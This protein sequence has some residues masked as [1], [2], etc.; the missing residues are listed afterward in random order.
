MPLNKETLRNLSDMSFILVKLRK[1]L[2][3]TEKSPGDLRRLIV[4]QTP[5]ENYQLILVWKFLKW[6]K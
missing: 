3:N 1:F 5:V 2:T 6:V 4:T